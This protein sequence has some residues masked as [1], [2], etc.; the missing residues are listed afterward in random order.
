[1]C[2]G[3]V[4]GKLKGMG[5]FAGLKCLYLAFVIIVLFIFLG[6]VFRRYVGIMVIRQK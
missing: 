1:M 4:G 3:V 2:S 5:F 6:F